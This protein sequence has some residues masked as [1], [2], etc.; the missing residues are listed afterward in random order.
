MEQTGLAERAPARKKRSRAGVN[1]R[2]CGG[3]TR[4]TGEAGEVE[5]PILPKL[6]SARMAEERYRG[7]GAN[8][9]RPAEGLANHADVSM[10]HLECMIGYQTMP[11]AR[12]ASF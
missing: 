10:L 9:E 1:L 7:T 8:L 12:L 6:D 11:I 5:L 3:R 2:A 4:E